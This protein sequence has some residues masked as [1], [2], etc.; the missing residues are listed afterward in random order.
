M[1]VPYS[2]SI[3]RYV[4]DPV[5]REF[6]NIGV[7]IYSREA[8]FLRAVCTTNYGRITRMF[9]RIDGNRF[10]QMIRY[11]QGQVNNLGDDLPSEL[12]FEPGPA[13]EALLAKV[14]PPDDSSFQFSPAGVGLASDLE[15]TLADLFERY[16]ERY[17]TLADTPR[18][19]EEE[20]W[21]VFREPLERR[22]LTE[23][24]TPKRVVA[25]NYEYEFQHA[26]KNGVWHLYEP[27]SFDLIEASSILEKANRWVGRATSL[28]DSKEK[29]HIHMLLGEPQ[30]SSLRAAF[31][32]ARNILSKMPGEKELV[33]ESEAEDFADEVAREL[34]GERS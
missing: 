26:W 6:L 25:Q 34:A 22:H 3:L 9:A 14:L 4:H 12:P 15:R 5:T 23:K 28:S 17:S 30:D 31:Q 1:K 16:V 8:K 24:L 27:V 7:V 33:R 32:K 13:I 2:F 19:D 18:R 11:I 21:R 29:F 10:R 20:V